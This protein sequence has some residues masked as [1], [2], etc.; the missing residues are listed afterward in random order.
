MLGDDERNISK[1][2]T[3]M[4]CGQETRFKCG[5]DLGNYLGDLWKKVFI[6]SGDF[7]PPRRDKRS[8][9]ERQEVVK[10]GVQFVGDMGNQQWRKL[11]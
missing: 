9:C 8:K 10:F 3:G 4:I 5:N 7:G 6:V 11:F 1:D 2:K